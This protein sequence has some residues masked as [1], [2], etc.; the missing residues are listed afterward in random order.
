MKRKH[1]GV[2][3]QQAAHDL[4]LDADT[5]A[6]DDPQGVDFSRQ[7]LVDIGGDDVAGFIGSK[8][9]QIERAVDREFNRS[10]VVWGQV[11]VIYP[12]GA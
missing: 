4:A 5:L 10:V 2:A 6:V 11:S 12:S 8:L 3:T 7:A 9:M 1:A